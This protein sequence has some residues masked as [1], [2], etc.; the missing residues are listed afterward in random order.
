MTFDQMIPNIKSKLPVKRDVQCVFQLLIEQAIQR[1][2]LPTY[3][4][5]YTYFSNE[6]MIII[7]I[8]LV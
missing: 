7:L 8:Q 3:A 6:T 4:K 2:Y 1:T 5:Q